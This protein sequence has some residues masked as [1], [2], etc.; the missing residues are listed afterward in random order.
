MCRLQLVQY[1]N[2]GISDDLPWGQ[3]MDFSGTVH[4][5]F[6]IYNIFSHLIILFVFSSSII[7]VFGNNR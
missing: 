6:L 2:C 4:F 3:G 1:W 7:D 5:V